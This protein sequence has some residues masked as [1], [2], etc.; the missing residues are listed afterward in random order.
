MMPS[1]SVPKLVLISPV[2]EASVAQSS[3]APRLA[4]LAGKRVG[5]LDNSKSRAGHMLDAV[6]DILHRQYGFTELVRRRKPSASKP[7]DPRVIEDLANSCDLV[8]VGVGD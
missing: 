6:A 2:N 4:S 8:L 5:L 7:A 1:E 3:L